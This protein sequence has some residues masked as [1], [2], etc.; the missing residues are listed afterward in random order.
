MQRMLGNMAKTALEGNAINAAWRYKAYL[1]ADPTILPGNKEEMLLKVS[2]YPYNDEAFSL[3]LGK[4]FN[5]LVP[6]EDRA[7]LFHRRIYYP[8]LKK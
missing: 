7:E 8:N 2:K 5:D 6:E 4:T 3:L 1:L